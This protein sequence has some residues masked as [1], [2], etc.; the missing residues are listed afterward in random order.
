MID[1]FKK[2]DGKKNPIALKVSLKS[3]EIESSNEN[4]EGDVMALLSRNIAKLSKRHYSLM[5]K[6]IKGNKGESVKKEPIVC[7]ECKKTCHR[8]PECVVLK[9]KQ[10]KNRRKM[11]TIKATINEDSDSSSNSV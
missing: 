11:K 10:S 4:D 3:C 2:E 7:Y 8:R 5:K 9:K 1:D 6:S